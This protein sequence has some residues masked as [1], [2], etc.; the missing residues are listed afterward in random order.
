MPT[1][2][3]DDFTISTEVNRLDLQV[4][5]EFLGNQAYWSLGRSPEQVRRSIDNS[6]ATFGVF[7]ESNSG[8][9]QV[10][11]ARLVSDKTTFAWLCDVFILPDARGRGLGKWLVEVVAETTR[12]WGIR[13]VL[14]ATRDAHGLYTRVGFRA[15]S[16]PDRW[17]ALASD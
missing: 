11:F 8:S 15:L 5:N 10:G 14:L 1:W 6:A 13:T 2:R 9:R 4:V 3:R 16:A 7:Q 12:V 17:M